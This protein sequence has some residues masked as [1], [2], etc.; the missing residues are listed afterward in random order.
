MEIEP[1]QGHHLGLVAFHDIARVPLESHTLGT[2]KALYQ[3]R[4][5]REGFCVSGYFH[6]HEVIRLDDP[7]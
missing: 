2:G 6:V 7:S 4:H 5:F 1:S 3:H